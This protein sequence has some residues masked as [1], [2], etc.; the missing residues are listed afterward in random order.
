[1]RSVV[2]WLG[3]I[4]LWCSHGGEVIRLRWTHP[5]GGRVSMWTFTQKIRAQRRHPVFLSCKEVGILYTC[6]WSL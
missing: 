4:H 1:M 3:A 5:D 2:Q 6:T